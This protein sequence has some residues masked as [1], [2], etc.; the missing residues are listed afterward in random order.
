MSCWV[1]QQVMPVGCAGMLVD[2]GMPV[3]YNVVYRASAR[4]CVLPWL[5]AGSEN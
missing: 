5:L 1:L 4:S 3:D 2:V